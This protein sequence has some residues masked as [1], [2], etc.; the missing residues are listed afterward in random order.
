MHLSSATPFHAPRRLGTWRALGSVPKPPSIILDTDMLTD[1]DDAGALALLHALA[2]N[3][4]ARILG[5][6][7][8]GQDVHGKHG[9]VV[10]AI[11]HYYGRG[12]L[13]IGVC[14]RPEGSSPRKA[15]SY[16]RAVFAE[17]PHDGLTDAE[18]PDAL[19]SLSPI[20]GGGAGSQRHHR[21]HRLPHQPRQPAE[22]HGR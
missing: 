4:E 14:K 11:N 8:N 19:T 20:A 2:D 12:D 7:L 21:Q 1:C 22:E 16:S 13:P 5:V 6:V 10:S 3:G 15:S 9:A 18:R 17:F